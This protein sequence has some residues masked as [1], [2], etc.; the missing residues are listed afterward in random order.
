M[1]IDATGLIFAD[2]SRVQLGELTR[3]RALAAVPFGGRYRIIDFMLSNMV[4]SG[5]PQVGVSTVNKYRSLMDHLGT[6]GAWDLDHKTRGLQLL[7]PFVASDI[8]HD[9]SAS[10]DLSGILFHLRALKRKYVVVAGSAAILNTTFNSA[11]EEHIDSGADITVFYNRDEDS[12]HAARLF[13]ILDSEERAKGLSETPES[14]KSVACSL[15]VLI[16]TR[17]LLI[18]LAEELMSRDIFSIDVAGLLSIYY[19]TYIVRGREY[20]GSVLRVDSIEAYFNSTLASLTDPLRSAI[21]NP[22]NPIFTKIKDEAPTYYTD[23]AQASNCLVSDGCYIE[24]ELENSLVFRNVTIGVGSRLKNCIIGQNSIVSEE[25]ELENV[26]LDKN[27]LVRPGIKMKG[28]ATGPR[29]IT[30][31]AII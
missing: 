6:G 8:Q 30:K 10:C 18:H 13:L 1:N 19:D 17:E 11:L 23:T 7:P 16:M 29:V 2:D 9:R 31:G 28:R 25:C 5:M 24:G 14:G 15:D 12:T 27:C 3:N 26:I 20:T 22:P 4:N 21:Y